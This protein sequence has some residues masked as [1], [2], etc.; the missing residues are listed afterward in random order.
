MNTLNSYFRELCPAALPYAGRQLYMHSFDARRPTMPAGFEDYMHPVLKLLN[1]AAFAG[2]F[3]DGT[4]HM[5]VDEKIVA[6]GMSQRRPGPHVDGRFSREAMRWGHDGPGPQW[7]HN[8]NDITGAPVGRMP[9]IVAASVP[10]CRAWEGVFDATPADD[11]DLSH[12]SLGEGV[13]LPAGVAYWLSPDCV[14]E[15]M[16]FDRDTPRTFLRLALEEAR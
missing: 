14:H 1:A 13:V 11:G 6:A 9:I 16:R 2:V 12:L 4:V 3:T 7:L 8:C 10:G 5:T 15:S